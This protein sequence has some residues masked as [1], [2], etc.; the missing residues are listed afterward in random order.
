MKKLSFLIFLIVSVYSGPLVVYATQKTDILQTHV[1]YLILSILN[2]LMD[3]ESDDEYAAASSSSGSVAIA[4]DDETPDEL[5]EGL[6]SSGE[7]YD[8]F[9]ES[10][11]VEDEAP[12]PNRK[13]DLDHFQARSKPV[14]FDVHENGG[15]KPTPKNTS[16]VIPSSPVANHT[17][18]RAGYY[19]KKSSSGSRLS[20]Q[21]VDGKKM[22][23]TARNFAYTKKP[24]GG[25][26]ALYHLISSSSGHHVTSA[27][28]NKKGLLGSKERKK[29]NEY[30]DGLKSEHFRFKD[31]DGQGFIPFDLGHGIDFS[32]SGTF[33]TTKNIHNYTPQNVGYNRWI[34]RWLVQNVPSDYF[35]M[36]IAIYGQDEK[37][38]EN[39]TLIPEGFLFY[40]IAADGK[41]IDAY[42][43]PNWVNYTVTPEYGKYSNIGDLTLIDLARRKF[44]LLKK[45]LGLK[46]K[47]CP[48]QYVAEYCRIPIKILPT[49]FIDAPT[50]D[51]IDAY[52][53]NALAQLKTLKSEVHQLPSFMHDILTNE[54]LY[55][56]L[57]T[58]ATLEYNGISVGLRLIDAMVSDSKDINLR[59]IASRQKRL[60]DLFRILIYRAYHHYMG[61]EEG[62]R[63]MDQLDGEKAVEQ[64]MA[65]YGRLIDVGLAQQAQILKDIVEQQH[66]INRAEGIINS[67]T[68][69]S[70]LNL[71]NIL[72]SYN[73]N[74][75]SI[76]QEKLAKRYVNAQLNGESIQFRYRVHTSETIWTILGLNR[77][78]TLRAIRDRMN[79]DNDLRGMILPCI[80]ELIATGRFD[81]DNDIPEAIKNRNNNPDVFEAFLESD[82]AREFLLEVMDR[83][84][85]DD[86]FAVIEALAYIYQRD[87]CILDESQ[88]DGITGVKSIS[89][90][91]SQ[92]IYILKRGRRY[93][94]LEHK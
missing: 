69:P 7:V 44:G 39:G 4:V 23:P 24:T 22:S 76:T 91:G 25:T 70:I 9:D 79:D 5:V 46:K 89:R 54:L 29:I 67:L 63:E 49:N 77:E 36:E 3:G 30:P 62:K 32:N 10:L 31:K 20:L 78:D 18:Q 73:N 14:L 41:L 40:V 68:W 84:T 38:T 53:R 60:I 90:S 87:I 11:D 12:S 93:F 34:R 6:V 27:K 37:R 13:H 74:E 92:S 35:Y 65:L 43:F 83:F 48:A 59:G 61:L 21:R 86:W 47:A 85:D 66:K 82:E 88:N 2:G 81:Q 28:K 8:C 72:S 52:I 58:P 71:S 50:P 45:A 75:N 26:G 80:Q 33:D 64:I 17:P 19:P 94:K 16:D 42:Y 55:M 57:A 15:K 56:R 51:N 1:L